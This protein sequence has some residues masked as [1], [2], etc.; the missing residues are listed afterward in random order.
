[1]T[2]ATT[3]RPNQNGLNPVHLHLVGMLN[4]NDSEEV[5]ERLQKVLYKF[6]LDEFE[7]E[8]EAMFANEE[9]TEELIEKGA[10][11]HFHT[12]Y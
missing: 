8:K 6:Y 3:K 2:N 12:E 5:Q 1:M 10:K 9:I 4:F 7:R 11:Q